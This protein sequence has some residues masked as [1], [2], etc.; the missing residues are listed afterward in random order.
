MKNESQNSKLL[1]S[2]LIGGVAARILFNKTVPRPGEGD[3]EKIIGKF[4]GDPEKIKGY[5]V[6]IK[7]LEEWME[8]QTFE[9]VYVTSRD[10]LRLHA[11]YYAAK[12]KPERVAI[13]HHG[14]MGSAKDSIVHGRFFHEMGYEVLLLDLRAHGKSEGEYA[15]FGILDRFDT[16]KWVEYAK[17]RFGKE[18]KIVLHGVSMGA[19]AVLMS[20]GIPEVRD[21][22]SAAISDCGF[23]S[24]AEIFANV[25]KEEY[26]FSGYPGKQI[27]KLMEKRNVGYRFDEYSTKD[28]LKNNKKVPVLFIHGAED[29]FVPVYMSKEN[30]EVCDTEKKLLLVE[31]AGHGFSVFEN[32]ELYMNTEKEFLEKVVRNS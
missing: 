32:T 12:K 2:G 23:T 14:Y 8:M 1:S 3:G 26:H 10:G 18:I 4:F 20:L 17:N 11:L 31:H 29:K 30:Y 24:P 9:D 28:A 7:Q 13:I 16:A 21:S 27:N 19:A 6:R 22:I 15:G 25:M 5:K